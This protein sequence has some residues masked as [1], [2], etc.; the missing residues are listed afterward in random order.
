M[1][2]RI[3][4]SASAAP[5][6]ASAVRASSGEMGTSPS[7]T[8]RRTASM[9][10]AASTPV[11]SLNVSVPNA[12]PFGRTM[13]RFSSIQMTVGTLLIAYCSVS[14]CCGSISTGN[15]MPSVHGR[16]SSTDS[17]IATPRTVKPSA[18]S[19]SCSACHPGRS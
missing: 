15:V 16:T 9:C 18:A 3:A 1:M 10:G 11:K 2:R 14:V 6:S 4:V 8:H 13:R 7:V 19:S 17:S 5:F 12:T